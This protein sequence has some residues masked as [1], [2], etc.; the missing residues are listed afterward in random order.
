[1]L[2][3]VRIE[4]EIIPIMPGGLTALSWGAMGLPALSGG[5]AGLLALS[6][7]EA[8]LPAWVVTIKYPTRSQG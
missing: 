5:T 8:E 2:D 6:R 4:V 3:S 1:M 7:G